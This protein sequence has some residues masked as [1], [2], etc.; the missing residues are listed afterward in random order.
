MEPEFV[1][2]LFE[3]QCTGVTFEVIKTNMDIKLKRDIYTIKTENN[4]ELK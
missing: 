4:E 2:G 3:N 1:E